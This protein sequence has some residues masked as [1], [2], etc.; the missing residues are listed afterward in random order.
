[1]FSH[2]SFTFCTKRWLAGCVSSLQGGKMNRDKEKKKLLEM[3]LCV[4]VGR[5]GTDSLART[6]THAGKYNNVYQV[7]QF[8][9]LRDVISIRGSGRAS[10]K[11]SSLLAVCC[12]RWNG[13]PLMR[14]LCM[15]EIHKRTHNRFQR[16]THQ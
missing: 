10:D 13:R 14:L 9:E 7:T 5:K 4:D 3:A 8:C 6:H 2:P 15:P 1:M 12:A 11:A 16:R